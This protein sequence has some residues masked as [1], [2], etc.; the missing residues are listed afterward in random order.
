[1]QSCMHYFP[2]THHYSNSSANRK[3]NLN[4]YHIHIG[5]TVQLQR[6]R[7]SGMEGQNISVCVVL[8]NISG[9][10]RRSLVIDV[11]VTSAIADSKSI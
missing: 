5:A 6:E 8:L 7:V 3:S 2:A 1:M 11:R 4:F 10:V 9:E